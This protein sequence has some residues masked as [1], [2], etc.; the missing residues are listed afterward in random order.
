M[1]LARKIGH[2]SITLWF[3]MPIVS[4]L[5]FASEQMDEIAMAYIRTLAPEDQSRIGIKEMRSQGRTIH[6]D[7]NSHYLTSLQE[8]RQWLQ[9]VQDGFKGSEIHRRELN[10]LGTT[11]DQSICLVAQLIDLNYITILSSPLINLLNPADIIFGSLNALVLIKASL[12][13]IAA[14]FKFYVHGDGNAR[15]F[16]VAIQEETAKLIAAYGSNGRYPYIKHLEYI[17]DEG[18]LSKIISELKTLLPDESD[19]IQIFQDQMKHYVEFVNHNLIPHA[20]QTTE[21]PRH[22]YELRLKL[23]GVDAKP[24]ELIA[25]G[26]QEFAGPY[27]RYKEL[28]NE[29]A[30]QKGDPARFPTDNPAIVLNELIKDLTIEDPTE[31]I[32]MYR[33]AQ[34]EIEQI[35]RETDFV[36]L[37]HR[38]VVVRPGTEAEEA[39]MPIPHVNSPNFIGNDGSVW[40]EFV[41]CDL[42][43]NSNTLAAYPLTAHEG[44]PGHDLQFSRMVEMTL[45]GEMNLFESVL[46]KNTTNVEGWAHYVEYAMSEHFPPEVRLSAIR[47]QLLRMARSFLDPQINLG[48]IKHEDVVNYQRDIVGFSDQTPKSEAD[49]YSFKFPGQAVSYRYGAQKIMDLRDKLKDKMKDKFNLRRFHDAILSF[50]LMPVNLIEDLV[51]ERM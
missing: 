46:S 33:R 28:A 23:Y 44:R 50:G 24:E 51:E 15:P 2:I 45:N 21:L 22:I 7:H 41:L 3:V 5:T 19:A 25:R 49:R 47:D 30:A 43:G 18:K 4:S 36:S 12:P 6:H 1:D 26:L 11:L 31:V 29:I 17:V 27:Q 42:K 20:A 39:I 13:E 10:L 9:S 38:P 35:I 48:L 40:P 32:V 14:R 34:K 8:T 37:P 16:V